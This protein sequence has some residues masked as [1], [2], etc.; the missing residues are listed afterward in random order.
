MSQPKARSYNIVSL[1]M[2]QGDADTMRNYSGYGRITD[3]LG[4]GD[5]DKD[6]ANNA[7]RTHKART[8]LVIDENTI[9]EIDLDCYERNKTNS[10]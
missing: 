3:T 4:K 7:K 1:N 9:Y 6:K 5:C 2:L 10:R 8:K